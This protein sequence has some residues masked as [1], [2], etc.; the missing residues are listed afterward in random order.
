[1]AA[2]AAGRADP[3][4]A[5]SRDDAMAIQ[6]T[7]RLLQSPAA[8]GAAPRAAPLARPAA[9]QAAAGG[10]RRPAP[11]RRERGFSL[12]VIIFI[13]VVLALLG[14]ALTRLAA[15]GSQSVAFETLSTRAFYAAESGAQW[16]MAQLFPLNNGAANCAPNTTLNFNP[17]GLNGCSATVLCTLQTAG[18]KTF[19]RVRSQGTCGTG[20]DAAT[21]RIEVGAT[22]P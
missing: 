7:P 17:T 18:G 15:T 13:L 6:K 16:G 4:Y 3:E 5:V 12:P 10:I 8:D 9:R 11:G 19:Y 2:G 20:A 21:R 14:T 22:N 1:M